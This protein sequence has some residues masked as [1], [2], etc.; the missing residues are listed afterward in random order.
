MIRLFL[1]TAILASSALAQVEDVYY[2]G[3]LMPRNVFPSFDKGYLVAYESSDA[4]SVY[5]R[6]GKLA[7]KATPTFPGADFVSIIH[8]AADT[9]GTAIASVETGRRPPHHGG[10]ALLNPS[11]VELGVI[12]T[13]TDWFP[14]EACFAPDHSIW[15][16][17]WRNINS[18]ATTD[19]DILRHYDRAGHMLGEFL[20]RSTF[21]QEPVGPI[22]GGWHITASSNRLGVLLYAHTVLPH[23]EQ[24]RPGQWTE[25]DFQGNIL[26]AVEIPR[27]WTIAAFT[28]NG[29]VFAQDMNRMSE[30]LDATTGAWRPVPGV[31]G[32]RLA[33]ADGDTLVF[34]IANQNV[35]I[36]T[37]IQ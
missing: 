27:G 6:D 30:A 10:L 16:V 14:V 5:G 3:D 26:R 31:Q 34:K 22:I 25:L 18:N 13:G 20:P 36:R 9:D 15:A 21:M 29:T 8:A 28:A 11:G 12:D 37:P 35:I 17:G 4:I 1:L 7:Y 24:H 33:G 19:Y 2:E 32:G 23:S